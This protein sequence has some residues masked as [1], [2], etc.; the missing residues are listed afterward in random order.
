MPTQ[1]YMYNETHVDY[2]VHREKDTRIKKR[3][4]TERERQSNI[5]IQT[6]TTS[7]TIMRKHTIASRLT[8]TSRLTDR[9]Y[10]SAW[11]GLKIEIRH[12]SSPYEGVR[13]VKPIIRYTNVHAYTSRKEK[14]KKMNKKR[15]K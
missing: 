5:H 9:Y 13:D 7:N 3:T 10:I 8:H 2:Y 6:Q 15:E 4:Y 1:T 12:C 14:K 11:L